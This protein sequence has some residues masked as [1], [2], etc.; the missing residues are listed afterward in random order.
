MKRTLSRNLI[1]TYWHTYGGEEA[2]IMG[3]PKK[4]ND[5]SWW[6]KKSA[7]KKE[8]GSGGSTSTVNNGSGNGNNSGSAGDDEEDNASITY[9][10]Q[11][12]LLNPSLSPIVINEVGWMG[13]LANYADEWIELKNV[14]NETVN[15]SGWQLLDK[16]NQIKIA[17][18][19][20]DTID[21]NE[22]YLLERTD[23][24]S[25]PNRSA[26]KIYSGAL[27]DSNESL[28]LF[29]A[30]CQLVDEVV[31][32]GSG[33]PGG[34]SANK[35]SMERK[36]DLSGWQT[37]AD[38][39]ADSVTGLWATPRRENSNTPQNSENQNPPDE[40]GGE[41]GSEDAE[42]EENEEPVEALITTENIED[43]EALAV[44]GQ[45]NAVFLSWGPLESAE[46]YDIYYSLNEP[47]NADNLKNISEYAPINWT[48]ED[49]KIKAEIRDTYYDSAYHFAV[50]G[51]DGE[52]NYSLI[53][54]IVD[55]SI[56]KANNERPLVWGDAGYTGRSNFDGPLSEETG[57]AEILISGSNDQIDY[58]E[59]CL[60]PIIDENGAI[61]FGSKIDGKQGL[62]SFD[63][64]G[65]QKWF[66]ESQA[67]YTPSVLSADGTIYN[68][69]NG[70]LVAVKP[71]GQLKWEENLNSI[72]TQNP[73]VDSN[74]DIYVISSQSGSVTLIKI[75]DN[76]DGIITKEN[77]YDF[78]DSSGA[79]PVN[80]H[81]EIIFDSNDN[82]YVSIN[83]I[84]FVFDPAGQKISERSFSV[85]F[86]DDY[87]KKGGEEE[88]VKIKEII[89]K[90]N[91][92]FTNV[93][94]GNCLNGDNKCR[95]ALYAF[96]INDL[97]G[98]PLWQKSIDYGNLAG[99]GDDEIYYID[100]GAG[101]YGWAWNNL[102]ALK[103]SDGLQ[104]WIKRNSG[105]GITPDDIS[106]ISIDA[107]NNIYLSRGSIVYGFDPKLITNEEWESGQI[108][109]V[110]GIWGENNYPVAIGSGVMYLPARF[111][112]AKVSY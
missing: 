59:F 34:E 36:I 17:F 108:F 16:D 28:R 106:L 46:D 53:S 58:N 98:D 71:N 21:A 84:L 23:D 4:A 57:S 105:Q 86:A 80:S 87:E 70:Y 67:S 61:I 9:C 26:N 30:D 81:S 31:A 93:I 56:S 19:N 42:D 37:Y 78:S 22:F 107:Q 2:A 44:D 102:V 90:N 109:S 35:K 33:W 40:T 52:N 20:I 25:V 50:K 112:I 68:I 91:I 47:I 100:K 103:L 83:N 14:S 54:N 55:F 13:T 74:G 51:K 72:I 110:Y 96:D 7:T 88:A 89:T 79:D 43:L 64:E 12:D 32:S 60:P 92:I 82:L 73:A 1:D 27:S 45:K 75:K 66:F 38:T 65:Q 15:L 5:D 41:D 8:T 69:N 39:S 77:L 95:N 11:N 10:S 104:S 62:Y 48:E 101:D 111:Q 3:T 97:G 29:N 63:K 24:S 18:K 94:A 6:Y 99:A 76:K 85:I 49:G